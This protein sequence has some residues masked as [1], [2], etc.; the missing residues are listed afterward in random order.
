MKISKET[1]KFAI[2]NW[3]LCVIFKRLNNDYVL[4]FETNPFDTNGALVYM[5]NKGFVEDKGWWVNGFVYVKIHNDCLEF[6]TITSKADK[7]IYIAQ[8]KW[9]FANYVKYLS[10]FTYKAK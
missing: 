6:K 9:S 8:S 2:Y 7:S 5:R 3:I 10:K 1:V 4:M